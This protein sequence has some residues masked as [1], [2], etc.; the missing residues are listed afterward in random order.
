MANRR[1]LNILE[2]GVETW[3]RWREENSDIE[4]DLRGANLQGKEL[5]GADFS[6]ADI[7]S[8]NFSR[9]NLRGAQ[10]G[11]AKAG[12]KRRWAILLVLSS[13]LLALLSG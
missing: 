12:L 5:V 13:W 10:F 6:D 2:Q 1:H 11:Q 3:N 4:P 8:T 7:R 9:A